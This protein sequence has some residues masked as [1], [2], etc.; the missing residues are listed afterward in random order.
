MSMP[1][2]SVSGKVAAIS[3]AQIPPAEPRSRMIFG[4]SI[5]ATVLLLRALFSR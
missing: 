3:N 4:F 5:G 1:M 2:T